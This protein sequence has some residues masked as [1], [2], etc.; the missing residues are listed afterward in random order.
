MKK[1]AILILIILIGI[2]LLSYITYS[3][4][5]LSDSSIAI[6]QILAMSMLILSGIYNLLDD[7]RI[8]KYLGVLQIALAIFMGYI[9]YTKLT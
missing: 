5:D 1:L 8:M 9:V 3:W 7:Y 4:N 6:S 2:A